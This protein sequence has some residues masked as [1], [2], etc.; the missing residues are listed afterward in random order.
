[1]TA[2][3]DPIGEHEAFAARQTALAAAVLVFFTEAA[4]ALVQR[5]SSAGSLVWMYVAHSLL[6][7]AVALCLSMRRSIDARWSLAAFCVLALPMLPMFW[8]SQTVAIDRG[9][10]WQPFV[11]RK[12][13][14]LGLAVLTPYSRV[15]ALGLLA[16]FMVESAAVWA[17]LDRAQ[18]TL[19]TAAGEPWVTLIFFFAALM[20]VVQ[21]WYRDRVERELLE[22][23]GDAETLRQLIQV[24]V[25]VRDQV[26]TPLQTL[27]M[28]V[29]LLKKRHPEELSALE[30][31]ERALRKLVELSRSFDRSTENGHAITRMRAVRETGAQLE[32]LESR[33]ST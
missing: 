23:R 13:M 6:A 1:M 9:L 30:R 3:V 19:A 29:A 25:A 17:H 18:A 31:M 12:L 15:V 20:I 33:R 32:K 24:S 26:N 14:L 8:V 16:A 7:G 11:G 28:S 5:T 10:I 21:R 2:G 27:E 22:A 4:F